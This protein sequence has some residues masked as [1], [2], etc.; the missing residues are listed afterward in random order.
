MCCDAPLVVADEPTGNL[1]E[2]NTVEVID[3]FQQ[4]AH[5]QHKC[6]IIVTHE[7]EVAARCDVAIR[8]AERTFRVEQPA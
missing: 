6:V 3:L 7:S 1:D 5:E 8:L 4:I 2:Q